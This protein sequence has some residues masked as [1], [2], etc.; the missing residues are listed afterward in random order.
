MPLMHAVLLALGAAAGADPYVWPLKLEPQLTSSFAEYRPGRFH[1]GIDLRT[2]GV[3]REVFAADD[4][5]VSRV[6]CSPYGYGK[7]VY[8]QM[9]DG[10]SVVYAHLSDYYPALA[11]F[12]RT[13]QHRAESYTVDITLKPG[14]F[15]VARGQLIALS[16]QTGI[17]APHLHYELRD[18]SGEP[19]NPRLLGV[20]WPDTTAPIIRRVTIAPRGLDGRING[21]VRPVILDVTRNERGEYRT[22]PVDAMGWIGFGA[23][24]TDPGAGGY[25]LGVHRLRVSQAGEELFRMQHDR[26]SY[27][28]HRNAAVCYHP[29]LRHEGRFLVLWR[30]P[31]NVCASYAHSLGDGWAF[32]PP[33]GGDFTVEASDFLGNSVTVT[34]PVR[35]GDGAVPPPPPGGAVELEPLGTAMLVSARLPEG[36]AGVPRLVVNGEETGPM[37]SVHDR[38]YRG[39]FT[40]TMRG[41]FAIS[42]AHPALD[43]APKPLAAWVQGAPGGPIDLNG[44]R[45]EAPANAAYGT[46]LLRAWKNNQPP[47]LPMP[48]RSAAWEIWPENA[49]MFAPITVTLPLDGQAPAGGRVHV[50]RF[51]GKSWSRLDTSIAGGRATFETDETGIYVAME[52]GAAPA[53]S[54]ISPPEGYTAQTRR[55]ELKASVSDNGSGI[56]RFSMTCNGDWI[57]AAYDPEHAELRWERDEDLPSGRLT[58]GFHLTDAAGN[59]KSV[60][61]TINIP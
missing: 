10:N 40:P 36:A 54:N 52:D 22:A 30:W 34:V 38:L 44:L 5:Y 23:D 26:M 2:N 19:I 7:A 60:E 47:A 56:E 35:E 15:P 16:G 61:R 18:H 21:D 8:L 58:I 25:N 46:L 37:A 41:A 27:S 48:A 24:V 33:G 17:G 59:T 11:E 1:A 50:Y 39:V 49:A 6:R 53:I 45:I 13:E 42:V 4:G 29:Q 31:G 32:V 55:P 28:N 14:Q 9:N 51:G 3:G 43:A 12:V 20:T 57:L